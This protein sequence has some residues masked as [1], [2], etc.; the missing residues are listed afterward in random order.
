MSYVEAASASDIPPDTMR[1][2]DVGGLKLLVAN[3][4]GAFHAMRRSCPHMSADLSKGTLA[5]RIVTCRM[6]GAQFDVTT[7]Q[8]VAKPE[9]QH[10]KMLT[11][12]P[13]TFPV[14]VRDGKVMVGV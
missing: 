5:G 12:T 14:E 13:A 4:D 10:L 9:L 3:V 11:R 1:A 7:G 6:H 8:P 2:V